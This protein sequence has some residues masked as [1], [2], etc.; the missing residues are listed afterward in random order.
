MAEHLRVRRR[1]KR[2]RSN[3]LLR[4]C[5]SV[6]VVYNMGVLGHFGTENCIWIFLSGFVTNIPKYVFV[7]V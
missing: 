7:N 5:K 1:E 4:S 6:S 2:N 3:F